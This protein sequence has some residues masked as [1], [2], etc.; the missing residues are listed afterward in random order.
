M[1]LKFILFVL[2]IGLFLHSKLLPH[3]DK[4]HLKYLR[5]FKFFDSIYS[6]II[7]FLRKFIHPYQVG[8][9]LSIDMASLVFLIL[10]IVLLLV[11]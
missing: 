6:P 10:L 4:L 1:V 9:G 5:I 11:F 3:K 7:S 8:I 2:I